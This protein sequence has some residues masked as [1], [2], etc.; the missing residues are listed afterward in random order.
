MKPLILA[1]LDGW[2]YSQQKIGNAILSANTPTMNEIAANYPAC[3]LQASG[4]GVGM[5]FGEA[6]NSEVGH[7][8]I[9]AGRVI[10]QYLT[11]INKS[12]ETDE[13]FSNPVLL[14]A[15]D[16]V[17]KNSS[18]LH[19]VGLVTSGAV[20]AHISHLK[21]AIEFA[22]KN[23]MPFSVHLFTDGRDSGLK[24]G[25]HLINKVLGDTGS[26]ANLASVIGRDFAMDRNGNWQKTEAAY[27]LIVNASGVKTDK[28]SDTLQYYYDQD[29]TDAAIPA[30]VVNTSPLAK[31]DAI[32]FVNFREDSMRQLLKVFIEPGFDI[33][34]KKTPE[35]LYIATMTRYLDS[36]EL[37]V[38][39]DPPVI[40][41]G[42]TET[43]GKNGKKHFH[44]A[45]TEKYAHVTFF[46]NGLHN[47]TF[48]GETD[49]FLESPDNLAAQPEMRAADIAQKVV[50]EMDRDFY[51]FFV[52]NFANG[53]LLAHLGNLETTIKGVQAVDSALAV[54]L[55]KVTEKDG[56]MIITADHGN[57]ES[58]I[59]K[60]TGEKETRHNSSPVPLYLVASQ[61]RRERTESEI[62]NSMQN[63]AGLLADVAP[64][65]LAIMEIE[66]PVEMTGENLFAALG[67]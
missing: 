23:Q 59:S 4:L 47:K 21:A 61:Y 57:A 56:I 51:D 26:A 16:H 58:M 54:I 28:I 46:F 36:P 29:I 55:Q 63:A 20:H 52:I 53:D 41:N 10:F 25:A 6:G 19:I 33:F 38:L 32:F 11:R 1:I 34:L 67:L 18:R 5:T 37:H 50:S 15:L 43:L 39:F 30:T 22:Q 9:G 3:L 45:E 66:K 42:L 40:N 14:K 35:D 64:T 8:T 62:Q 48:D 7:M 12:I 44:I 31:G 27:N 13:F 65:I 24:D 2:G 60:T 49:F 17:R